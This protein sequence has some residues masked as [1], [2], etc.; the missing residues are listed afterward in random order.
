[1]WQ[2]LNELWQAVGWNGI[3]AIAAL[4]I[5]V[6][7]LRQRRKEPTSLQSMQQKHVKKDTHA[8]EDPK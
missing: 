6:D 8:C 3:S 5:A 1:M 2:L 7:A 4:L